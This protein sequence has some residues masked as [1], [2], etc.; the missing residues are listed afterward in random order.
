MDAPTIGVD[1]DTQ[2]TQNSTTIMRN[3]FP[4]RLSTLPTFNCMVLVF[5]ILLIASTGYAQNN[6]HGAGATLPYPLLKKLFREYQYNTGKPIIFE[7]IGSGSGL[8]KFNANAVDFLITDTPDETTL[9]A[10]NRIA[11][12]ISISGVAVAY[13]LPKNP[14]LKLNKAILKAIYSGEI[15]HW[16]DPAIAELNAP[17]LLPNLPIQVATRPAKSGTYYIFTQFL[18]TNSLQGNHVVPG[19]LAMARFIDETIGSV[20]F[21]GLNHAIDQHLKIARIENNVGAFIVPNPHVIGMATT[22]NSPYAYPISGLSWLVFET[23]QTEVRHL[24]QWLLET[25]Q[26]YHKQFQ[27]APLPQQQRVQWL[28]KLEISQ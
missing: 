5:S 3:L 28:K 18:D 14:D 17:E 27:Y 25:G 19:S 9:N 2:I 11:V 20:G 10:P 4:N 24:A 15:T 12:P 16:N 7:A 26:Y 6:L 23:K 13:N 21:L 8:A 22:E 1:S